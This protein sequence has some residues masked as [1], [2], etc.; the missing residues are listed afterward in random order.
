M[1]NDGC[2]AHRTAHE[3]PIWELNLRPQECCV[4]SRE[5]TPDELSTYRLGGEAQWWVCPHCKRPHIFKPHPS[6]VGTT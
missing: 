6:R 5:A 2:T 4:D 1:V 3:P